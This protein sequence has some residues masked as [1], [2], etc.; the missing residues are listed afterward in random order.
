MRQK[1]S[2]WL[3]FAVALLLP[4]SIYAVVHWYESNKSSLPVLGPAQQLKG[5][6]VPH[7]IA[8]F[9]LTNQQGET[10][11]LDK[12]KGKIVVADFFFT[13]CPSICP[14]MTANLKKVQAAYAGDEALLISSFTVDPERDSAAQL[15][16]YAAKFAVSPTHWDLLTGDK[17]E[18][19][20]LGRKSF[21]IIATDG[22]GG[23]DDFIHSDKFVLIDRQQRIR[24]FY[25]G[26]EA[27]DVEQ[28][29]KDIGKLKK[30]KSQ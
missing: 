26:T 11:T 16:R 8:P 30:E 19:Y 14:K 13:H 6:E 9:Q 12:W 28:M 29:I 18:L 10:V 7:T 5:N 17:K 20:K 23:P 2:I 3:F 4:V 25:S 24:G 1:W 22:D 27:A 21:L 15:A